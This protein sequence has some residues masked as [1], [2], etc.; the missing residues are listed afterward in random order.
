MF[1]GLIPYMVWVILN[2][3]AN[4]YFFGPFGFSIYTPICWGY[5]TLMFTSANS[6]GM[7][8]WFFIMY[9]FPYIFFYMLGNNL[10]TYID[11]ANILMTTLV[12]EILT[13]FIQM[14]KVII[15]LLFF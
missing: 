11:Y 2:P 15:Y 12:E 13:L 5:F 9:L 3:C 8:L 14:V 4:T 1:V 6:F 10:Y 7:T